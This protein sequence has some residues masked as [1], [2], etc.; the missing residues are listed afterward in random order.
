MLARRQSDRET[1]RIPIKLQYA[2]SKIDLAV[3]TSI[4]IPGY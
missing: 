1:E 2:V 4:S 3:V